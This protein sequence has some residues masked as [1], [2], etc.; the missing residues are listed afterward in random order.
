[1]DCKKCSAT[2][3]GSYLNGKGTDLFSLDKVK[4][5]VRSCL[6]GGIGIGNDSQ[7]GS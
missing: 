5:G 4:S 7:H 6:F 3:A 2:F 1:M